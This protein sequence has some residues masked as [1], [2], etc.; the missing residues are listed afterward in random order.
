MRIALVSDCYHPTKN[1]V[2]GMVALLR[3]ELAARGHQVTLI[4]P[5]A[6]RSS[7]A[8]ARAGTTS[9]DTAPPPIDVAVP[10]VPWLP[11]VEL[12]LAP[13]S[14]RSL[15]ELLHRH[16]SEVV[17]THTEGPLGRA[18]R[19]AAVSSGIPAVHTLHTLY[20]HYLHYLAPARLVPDGSARILHG[21][22]GRFLRPFDRVVAPSL[23]AV[24]QVATVAPMCLPVLIPNGVAPCHP[25]GDAS[26]AQ[27]LGH[28][29]GLR[30]G[31][32]ILVYVG[33]IAEEKRSRALFDALAR[34][35][36]AAAAV[37]AVLVGG[38]GQLRRLRARA[39]RL[40]LDDRILLPGYLEHHEVRQLYRLASVFVTASLSENH[41]LTL[42]EAAA[43]GL[44]L[45]VVDDAN[46]GSIV[47]DGTNGIVAADDD[48]LV[49]G[50]LALLDDPR[51]AQLGEGSRAI[52]A[53]YPRSG[54]AARVEALYRMVLEERRALA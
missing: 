27:Q 40:G 13:R 19:N 1:G 28:R 38:G 5:R 22:L 46:L 44:P 12:R 33:R 54:H 43:A 14:S 36:P 21:A 3:E 41:P 30:D 47:I 6:P 32:R 15:Q 9:R 50:A 11:S 34:R 20:D 35:L 49:G 51:R 45:V 23:A 18:A 8:R 17:H 29:L 25:S 42:L 26:S 52:A 2:T 7:N 4:A 24:E 16:G 53:R 37:T 10:S 39:A 48:A 31:D